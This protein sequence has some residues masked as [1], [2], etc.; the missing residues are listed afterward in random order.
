MPFKINISDKGKTLKIETESEV[1]VGKSIGETIQGK[2][3]SPDLEGYELQITG[4]SDLSGFPGQKGLEGSGYH[5][6]LLTKGFAMHD[7]KRGL[8]LKK[9]LRG[10][11]ISLKTHQINT[12]VKKQGSKNF[13]SLLP[14]KE[15]NSEEDTSKKPEGVLDEESKKEAPKAEEPKAE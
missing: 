15:A 1:I 14:K 12:I 10:E 3:I 6:K 11:E 9:T 4:T 5:R 2:D 7:K 8:R 13:D